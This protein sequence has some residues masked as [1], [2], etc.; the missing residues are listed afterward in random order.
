MS[1]RIAVLGAGNMGGALIGGI[2]NRVTPADHVIATTRTPERAA[3]LSAKY[4]I[5][6]TAGGNLE[7]AAQVDLIVL[8][9]KPG[10]L[11]KVVTEI[12]DALSGQKIL[13]SLAASV[14]ISLIE[15]LAGK[16]MPIFRAMPNIPVVVEE[17]ATAV[18]ANSACTPEQR[19]I[20][21]DIFRSV[22]VMVFVEEDMMHAV[23]ALSG[24]GPAYVYMVIEAMIA[25]GLKMGLSREVSTR[26]AE[27]TVLGAAKLVRETGLHP[28]V[29]RDQVITPGGVTISAIHELER[30]GL[31]SM[32]ISAIETAT[33]HSEERTRALETKIDP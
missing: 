32:L 19:Q 21:E 5:R 20:I 10:T 27:Q 8:A 24:S 12:R 6:A 28:A 15:K 31:R 3:E 4:G 7:A 29:L 9:V 22:G 16:R 30:H 18:A 23:T 25:G 26:L 1:I 17:G 11:T 2:V 13:L 14:P 33:R